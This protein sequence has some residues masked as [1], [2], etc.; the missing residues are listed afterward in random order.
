MVQHVLVCLLF[1]LLL[2]CFLKFYLVKS[3]LLMGS[4]FYSFISCFTSLSIHQLMQGLFL[5]FGC[6]KNGVMKIYVNIPLSTHFQL[7]QICTQECNGLGH[8]APSVLHFKELPNCF[9]KQLHHFQVL[10]MMQECSSFHRFHK[11]LKFS[12]FCILTILMS[13]QIYLIIFI[14]H[15]SND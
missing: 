8:K 9:P 2:V 15:S 10:V 3:I 7:C 6:Y 13:V 5:L 4:P 12:T 1:I 11:Q 14:L